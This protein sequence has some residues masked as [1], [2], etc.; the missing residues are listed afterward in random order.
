MTYLNGKFNRKHP[1]NITEIQLKDLGEMVAPFIYDAG[2]N[3]IEAP[4]AIAD[5]LDEVINLL[6]DGFKKEQ[7][8]GQLYYA[9]H[10]ALKTTAQAVR[11]CD[12]DNDISV[13]INTNTLALM[14]TSYCQLGEAAIQYGGSKTILPSMRWLF[15]ND[16]QGHG[17]Q[18]RK[19]KSQLLNE[20][21]NK[22]MPTFFK[23]YAVG[24]VTHEAL[25]FYDSPAPGQRLM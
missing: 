25:E 21:V 10:H 13:N 7:R 23:T 17:P 2:R 8:K 4:D 12:H 1:A 15:S 6:E 16:G 22:T 18:D 11:G 19:Y 3:N 14:N 20:M 9:L 5:A 24:D